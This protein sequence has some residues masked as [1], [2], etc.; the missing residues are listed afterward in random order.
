MY[1]IIILLSLFSII[2]LFAIFDTGRYSELL[3]FI[4]IILIIIL[5]VVTGFRDEKH[6]TDYKVYKVMYERDNILVEPSFL[7]IK[8]IFK[9]LLNAQIQWFMLFYA[10]LAISIKMIALKEITKYLFLSLMVFL[11]DLFLQ[12]DFTQIRAAVALS[13]MLLSLKYVYSREKAK[14]ALCYIL[15]IFFHISALM[16]IVIWFFDSKK[17]NIKLCFIL[18]IICFIFAIM[19]FNPTL[20]FTYI[21]LPYIQTKVFS[22][23]IRNQGRDVSANI[24]GIYSLTKLFLICIILIKHKIIIKYNKYTYILIKMQLL[25]SLSLLIFSQNMAAALRISEFF[26][27]A[28]IILFPFF[29]VI[30][31]NKLLARFV[32]FIICTGM[33]LLRIFR[34]KLILI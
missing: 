10:L 15:A 31:K 4:L 16:M 9:T 19:K 20:L 12:Q 26:S 14:F 21:P 24:F 2:S 18:I 6:V 13:F 7:I 33:I 1:L 22:Y 23:V 34:Y 8:Y 28:G 25:S 11:G 5:I 17:I 27:I 3:L 29:S 32:L 30:F